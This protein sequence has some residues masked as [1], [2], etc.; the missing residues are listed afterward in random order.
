MSS[1][2]LMSP[3]RALGLTPEEM[4]QLESMPREE[5]IKTVAKRT[6]QCKRMQVKFSDLVAAYKDTN[7]AKDKLT[8]ALE[9]QQDETSRRMKELKETHKLDID[10]RTAI[11]E[12]LKRRVAEKED[13][14][15]ALRKQLAQLE[16]RVAGSDTSI[17]SLTADLRQAV[18]SDA[19]AQRQLATLRTDLERRDAIIADAKARA[20]AQEKDTKAL[21]QQVEE[22]ELRLKQTHEKM[23]A[24]DDIKATLETV[25]SSESSAEHHTLLAEK[26][27]A[28]LD[29]A[30]RIAALETELLARSSALSTLQAEHADL[31]HAHAEAAAAAAAHAQSLT[32]ALDALT[33]EHAA[34]QEEQAA[35]A[36][37][38]KATREQIDGLSEQLAQANI[39]LQDVRARLGEVTVSEASLADR[40]RALEEELRGVKGD[41]GVY[42]EELQAAKAAL[43][44]Q[45]EESARLKAH[46]IRQEALFLE[47]KAAC[48]EFETKASAL[49]NA[50]DELDRQLKAA[51]QEHATRV[52]ELN[53]TIAGQE[54]SAAAASERVAQLEGGMEALQAQVDALQV[55]GE[56][57]Q[58]QVAAG[59]T[60]VQDLTATILTLRAEADALRARE[61]ALG[62][63]VTQLTGERDALLA[64]VAELESTRDTLNTNLEETHKELAAVEASR[65]ETQQAL[66]NAKA[67]FRQAAKL[68]QQHAAELK[69]TLSRQLKGGN[70]AASGT[71]SD[72]GSSFEPGS[73]ARPSNRTPPDGSNNVE[74]VR[75]ASGLSRV[76][77]LYLKNVFMKFLTSKPTE[78]PHLV[79]VVSTML[80]LNTT[81]EQL[82]RK[83]LVEA[84]QS[85]GWF[86]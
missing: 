11:V 28:L 41:A 59:N 64:Q 63:E 83:A 44:R 42:M 68:Q 15:Q 86:W 75:E 53:E 8:Q 39:E 65:A 84:P 49:Q 70:A 67:E 47:R 9:S 46:G 36:V 40:A 77:P 66:E 79:K 23:S 26:S 78:R 34:L 69:K 18:D 72:T 55:Q 25:A 31:Q 45:E 1:S 5:L 29:A 51:R 80:E 56:Q 52:G 22:L 60:T 82:V 20:K 33:A 85:S 13:E 4:A 7:A 12:S 35:G 71:D 76:N 50:R 2:S 19:A 48:A 3:A 30:G 54:A 21:Q 73:P 14:V 58:A 24:H 6:S 61:E 27:A 37:V 57:L 81:E 38:A 17:T 32:D 43:G 74:V 10:T 16:E 62:A